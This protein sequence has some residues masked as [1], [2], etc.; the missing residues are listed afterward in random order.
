MPN[1]FVIGEGTG[2]GDLVFDSLTQ[3][4]NELFIPVGPFNVKSLR[5]TLHDYAEGNQNSVYD[6]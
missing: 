3:E 6:S 4:M 5:R 2:C 1:D